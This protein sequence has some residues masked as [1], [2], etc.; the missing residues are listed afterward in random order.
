MCV[1]KEGSERSG[2]C[3][4]NDTTNITFATSAQETN[5]AWYHSRIQGTATAF[6]MMYN[7]KCIIRAA[8]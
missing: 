8:R 2:G 1:L 4:T 7:T 5:F 3:V 6:G